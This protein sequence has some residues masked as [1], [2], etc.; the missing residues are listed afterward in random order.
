MGKS[1]RALAMEIQRIK[2]AIPLFKDRVAPHFGASSRILLVMAEGQTVQQE[3]TWELKGETAVEIARRL[4][5]LGVQGII[6]GG[7]QRF[8]KEWLVK[9]GV[10]VVDNQ[11]IDYPA[12]RSGVPI[13]NFLNAP[14]G[15][16]LNPR[17]P[18]AD[19]SA[20]GG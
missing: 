20:S 12:A 1:L 15:G 4:I 5:D 16:E 14:R 6:C 3:A 17:P 8:L 7:I 11:K 2:L 19:K 9:K 10:A 18:L 13:G